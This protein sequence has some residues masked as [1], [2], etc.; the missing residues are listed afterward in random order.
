M[1]CGFSLAPFG[2]P[3]DPFGPPWAA[4]GHI[5]EFCQSW[6]SNSELLALKSAACRQKVRPWN[7]PLDPADPAEVMLGPRLR[8]TLPHA[9]GTKMRVVHKLPQIS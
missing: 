1:F 4:Q 8:A 3:V 7:S 9:P 5:L 6:T 2:V